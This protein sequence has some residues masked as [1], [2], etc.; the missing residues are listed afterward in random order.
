LI[1]TKKLMILSKT[2]V[3]WLSKAVFKIKS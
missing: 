2:K 1:D 3:C